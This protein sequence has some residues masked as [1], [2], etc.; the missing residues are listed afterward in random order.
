LPFI[1]FMSSESETSQPA[2]DG[3]ASAPAAKLSTAP[4]KKQRWQAVFFGLV[5][6]AAGR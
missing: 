1:Q 2:G 6:V 3:G 5:L 4:A